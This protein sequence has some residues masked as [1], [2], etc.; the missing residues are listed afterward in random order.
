M[1]GTVLNHLQDWTVSPWVF[2]VRS[3]VATSQLDLPPG[4]IISLGLK[5]KFSK[6]CS[7]DRAPPS[8]HKLFLCVG[9]QEEQ[10]VRN[11]DLGSFTHE[12][13]VP[14]Q[15]SYPFRASWPH[16]L[17]LKYWFWQSVS[18]YFTYREK[19][20][21]IDV[22]VPGEYSGKGVCTSESLSG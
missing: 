17:S 16:P 21:Q 5:Q 20:G 18:K 12:L 4:P 1:P 7:A 2:W 8:L 3:F 13:C 22:C 10:R 9:Q 6:I 19:F 15:V 11:S 14:G